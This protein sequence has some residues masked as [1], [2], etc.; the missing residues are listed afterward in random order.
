MRIRS[1]HIHPAERAA[2]LSL[3]ALAWLPLLWGL[4]HYLFR[5][6]P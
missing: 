6:L 5:P 1:C 4:V 3:N 2:T